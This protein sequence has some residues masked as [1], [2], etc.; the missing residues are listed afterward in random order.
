MWHGVAA[1]SSPGLAVS[2]TALAASGCALA[3]LRAAAEAV[4]SCAACTACSPSV[5]WAGSGA[6]VVA[7]Q[8]SPWHHGWQQG[9]A[10][11][12]SKTVQRGIAAACCWTGIK[13]LPCTATRSSD[14]QGTCSCP[15][16]GVHPGHGLTC[17][18][19]APLNHGH[20]QKAGGGSS[21]IYL[22]CIQDLGSRMHTAC[23]LSI[24]EQV[25]AAVLAS[26]LRRAHLSSCSC[27]QIPELAAAHGQPALEVC[28]LGCQ[29][30]SEH[31]ARRSPRK[32]GRLCWQLRRLPSGRLDSCSVHLLQRLHNACQL[33]GTNLHNQDTVSTPP[34]AQSCFELPAEEGF[35]CS[36]AMTHMAKL[37]VTTSWQEYPYAAMFSLSR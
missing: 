29:L 13:K 26:S 11:L 24:T 16:P 37:Q 35:L 34:R 28:P 23:L 30:C 4:G 15:S 5:A 17:T 10:P 7:L 6:V 12:C 33:Q 2:T 1:G 20:T 14:I 25:Q 19:S 18:A 32:V 22:S 31:A 36:R 3:L 21:S 9:P 27:I 8:P